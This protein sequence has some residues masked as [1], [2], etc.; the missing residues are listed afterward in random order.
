MNVFKNEKI[1]KKLI[2]TLVILILFC[3]CFPKN[4]NAS[5]FPTKEEIAQWIA[6]LIFDGEYAI[7]AMENNLFCSKDNEMPYDADEDATVY[8][9]PETIIKGKFLLMDANIFKDFSSVTSGSSDYY[10]LEDY[11]IDGKVEMQKTVRGWYTALRNLSIV[12]LL[13]IL[14]Y[15][16]IRMM[17]TSLAAD[18]A[19]YKTMFKEWL[20]SLCLVLLMHYI[21][22]G[23]LNLS[24]MIVDAISTG[25][26]NSTVA[27]TVIEKINEGL[28]MGNDSDNSG[29]G[30]DK[31]AAIIKGA[32]IAFAYEI[33][34]FAIIIFTAIY[35]VK[36]M[37]RALILM[38]LI[39]LAPI[40]CITYPLDKIGDGKAQAFNFWLREFMYN[41]LIQPFHLLL[42]IVLLGSSANLASKNIVYSI[43]CYA[44]LLPAEKLIRE[45]FGFDKSK[46]GSPLGAMATGAAMNQLMRGA[47]NMLKDGKGEKNG[48]GGN[49]RNGGGSEESSPQL[50]PSQHGSM[51]DYDDGSVQEG[52][53]E[54]PEDNNDNSEFSGSGGPSAAD[55]N[56]DPN[57]DP[58]ER[59][60][61]EALEEQWADGQLD[62]EDLTDEQ[63]EQ[64]GLNR[65]DEEEQQEQIDTNNQQQEQS[66]IS[67]NNRRNLPNA[68]KNEIGRKAR[69]KYGT[70]QLATAR[71]GIRAIKNSLKD[72]KGMSKGKRFKAAAGAGI[73]GF[74]D[75]NNH[76][77]ILNQITRKGLGAVG[78]MATRTAFGLAGAGVAALGATVT[79]DLKSIGTAAAGGMAVGS[80]FGQKINGFSGRVNNTVGSVY[81]GTYNRVTGGRSQDKREYINNQKERDY[82]QQRLFEKNGGRIVQGRELDEEMERRYQ[83]REMGITDNDLIDATLDMQD[84][85]FGEDVAR[86]TGGNAQTISEVE[87]RL[88]DKAYNK[89][90]QNLINGNSEMNDKEFNKIYGRGA[91]KKAREH[92]ISMNALNDANINSEDIKEKSISKADFAARMANKYNANDF[93]DEKKMK[94]MHDTMQKE[95][96]QT[97][98]SSAEHASDITKSI[99]KDAAKLKGIKAPNFDAIN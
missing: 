71:G 67:G 24:Q 15:V 50:P 22:V 12:A 35:A 33:V 55:A 98:G 21:M 63:R 68:I 41:V 20:V 14:V 65:N 58:E 29:D 91:A 45:M 34:F 19:K 94:Q 97:S 31:K 48:N 4:V 76:N 9:T 99:M 39:L 36:Y 43:L 16:G 74:L 69:G 11:N 49:G 92:N 52:L 10:D 73:K 1:Q 25:G 51:E 77:G 80:R 27:E 75:P 56:T 64:L 84:E 37:K 6:S 62:E 57:E 70:A 66:T 60:E 54:N 8:L 47:S 53:N 88:S 3:F 95:Y 85:K 18:K 30:E 86:I 2:I 81:R 13:S 82:A 78:R 72:T 59:A 40:T 61:R 17:M 26:A 23:V 83:V 5:L 38:F 90:Y 32:R 44:M 28:N 46:L 42:Y 7:L 93:K 79:G 89:D 96:M 87:G